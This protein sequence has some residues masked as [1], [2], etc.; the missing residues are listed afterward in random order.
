MSFLSLCEWVTAFLFD[1][2]EQDLSMLYTRI[3]P[4]RYLADK[5]KS[6]GKSFSLSYR[7]THCRS[8]SKPLLSQTN[9]SM[10]TDASNNKLIY[11]C[12][13]AQS[14]W[15]LQEIRAICLVIPT[16]QRQTDSFIN[17][18]YT[19][20]TSDIFTVRRPLDSWIHHWTVS[21]SQYV[22]AIQ[23]SIVVETQLLCFFNERTKMPLLTCLITKEN[24]Q[25]WDVLYQ[26]QSYHRIY[27]GTIGSTIL[28]LTQMDTWL[29]SLFHPAQSHKLQPG[30][31]C[32]L[33]IHRRPGTIQPQYSWCWLTIRTIN[34]FCYSSYSAGSTKNGLK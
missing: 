18:F 19:V 20:W 33:F 14:I 8:K 26:W 10:M 30:S 1:V 31:K 13:R 22:T 2:I 29:T 11:V 15:S 25:M 34:S 7:K 27:F 28:V 21:M 23:N 17:F 16:V 12:L 5:N 6:Q 4:S 32:K 3:L 24:L 9:K